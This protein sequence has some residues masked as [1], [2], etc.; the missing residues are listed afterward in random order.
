MKQ[1]AEGA[2][3]SNIS[4]Q[5][6]GEIRVVLHDTSGRKAFDITYDPYNNE[7][8]MI[9]LVNGTRGMCVQPRASNHIVIMTDRKHR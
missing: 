1:K 4:E 8:D 3:A 6:N 7:L 2:S 9:S 5:D